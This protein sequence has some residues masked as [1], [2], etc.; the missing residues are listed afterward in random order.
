MRAAIKPQVVAALSGHFVEDVSV[1]SEH[2]LAVTSNGDVFAWGNNVDGQLGLGHTNTVRT[3]QLV[4][5]LI[6]KNIRKV[7]SCYFV[8]FN[9]NVCSTL[10]F[11]FMEIYFR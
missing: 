10:A 2:T 8:K 6:G 9:M 7:S 5:T 4:T 11:Y 3:P 1:G